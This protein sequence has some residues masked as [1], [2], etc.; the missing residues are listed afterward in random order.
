[1]KG[2]IKIKKEVVKYFKRITFFSYKTNKRISLSDENIIK[3]IERVKKTKNPKL[4]EFSFG[5]AKI[6]WN[7]KLKKVEIVYYYPVSTYV[8]MD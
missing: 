2:V 5:Y 4:I 8:E 7:K 6:L 3:A 1:M